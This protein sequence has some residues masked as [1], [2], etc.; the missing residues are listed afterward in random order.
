M[1][2]IKE[3]CNKDDINILARVFG[4]CF[5]TLAIILVSDLLF[6]SSRQKQ[7]GT[8]PVSDHHYASIAHPRATRINYLPEE[9][10]RSLTHYVLLISKMSY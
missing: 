10:G 9:A 3:T 2:N 5:R 8:I 7:N 4:S 6:F 1:A